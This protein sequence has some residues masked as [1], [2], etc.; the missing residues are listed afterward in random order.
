MVPACERPVTTFWL[1]WDLFFAT[2]PLTECYQI[3]RAEFTNIQEIKPKTKAIINSKKTKNNKHNSGAL[4]GSAGNN[5]S[6]Y[7]NTE[8]WIIVINISEGKLMRKYVCQSGRYIFSCYLLN[9][10]GGLKQQKFIYFFINLFIYLFI[11]CEVCEI[12]VPWPRIDHTLGSESAEPGPG[13][14]PDI[15]YLNTLSP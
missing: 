12:L 15:Y 11:F 2:K 6:S 8:I 7:I 9:K 14:S 1:E 13:N 3:F 4:H 10:L 5:V